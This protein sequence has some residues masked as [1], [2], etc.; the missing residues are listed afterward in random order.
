MGS[1]KHSEIVLFENDVFSSKGPC[2]YKDIRTIGA[3]Q[4]PYFKEAF[5]KWVFL[6]MIQN[7]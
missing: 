2:N 4:Y 6:L 1:S 3:T 5:L 7:M